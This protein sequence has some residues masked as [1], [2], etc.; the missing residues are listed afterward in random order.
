[1]ALPLAGI[2]QHRPR[3]SEWTGWSSQEENDFISAYGNATKGG[4]AADGARLADQWLKVIGAEMNNAGASMLN[5][6]SVSL[7]RRAGHWKFSGRFADDLSEKATLDKITCEVAN[8]ASPF[9]PNFQ[10][11][12]SS[13]SAQSPDEDT[14]NVG[15][16]TQEGE[17]V[18]GIPPVYPAQAKN[19]HIE[20]VVR[21][22]AT[23]DK[24]GK[25][26]DVKLT[27]GHPL[28][29][30]A[31]EEAVR[32]WQYKPTIVNGKPVIVV[33][34]IEVWFAIA[35]RSCPTAGIPANVR[36]VICVPAP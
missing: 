29:V 11:Q 15:L 6:L 32:Q 16:I 18:N 36:S 9:A 33:T 28:L 7:E 26:Q 23:I 4:N 17:L 12:S 13:L 27:N 25:V 2:P 22:K 21:F 5:T 19:A 35:P 14:I 34:T 8:N 10:Q 30:Q 1:M 31:A 3:W 20:G 24:M